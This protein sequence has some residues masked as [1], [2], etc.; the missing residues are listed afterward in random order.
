VRC[1]LPART[2]APVK[3][4]LKQADRACAYFEAVQLAGFEPGE[5]LKLFARPPKHYALVI[6]PLPAAEAQARYLHR[7]HLLS[8]A[9]G[10]ETAPAAFDTE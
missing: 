5:A 4:L 7:F 1:G 3:T 10:Y 6:E 2:P 8:E 9:A